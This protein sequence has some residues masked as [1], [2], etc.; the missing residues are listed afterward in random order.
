MNNDSITLRSIFTEHSGKVSDKWSMYLDEYNRLFDTYRDQPVRLLEIGIQNGGSLEILSK[1]FSNAEKLVGCDNN[2]VCAQLKYEDPKI[3]IVVADANTDEAEQRILEISSRFDFI[4][5]DGSHY[6]GDIV[7]SFARYFSHLS[8]GGIYIAEDLHCSYW[9]EFE[10]GIFQPD[11]SIA[12]FKRLADIINHEHWGVDITRCELMDSFNSKFSATMTEI[13]L[14]SIHSIE[15][16]NSMCVIR[17]AQPDANVIGSR[18]VVG[19]DALVC[20]DILPFHGSGSLMKSQ[21]DNPWS[22]KYSSVDAALFERTQEI[23]SLTRIVNMRD[24]EIINL[25]QTAAESALEHVAELTRIRQQLETKLLELEGC[26]I[27][28][29]QQLLEMRQA[30]E[31]QLA[32]QK[33][34]HAVL[35]Q[36][37]STYLH[38]NRDSV[39][40]LALL[41]KDSPDQAVGQTAAT[42]I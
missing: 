16:I 13:S 23:G 37:I 19:T 29:S 10:G 33:S 39:N 1:F 26:E 22:A 2:P 17:K 20:R 9:K 6:S 4:I 36:S 40:I 41:L 5:D 34:L 11:S 18:L 12:F 3:S 24:I 30:H 38:T 8:N 28:F 35:E 14:A 27:A 31:L 32:E 25:N 21:M 42:V 15:F 7:R